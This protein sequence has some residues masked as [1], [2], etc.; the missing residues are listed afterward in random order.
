MG[1]ILKRSVFPICCLILF[2]SPL[3]AEIVLDGSTGSLGQIEAPDGNYDIRM[4]YGHQAG[5]NLF[6]SFS[7]FNIGTGETAAF[8]VSS[9]I[10][11]IISRVT[12]GSESFIDGTIRSLI[13]DTADISAANLYLLNP[14]GILFGPNAALDMGGSFH[15]STADYLRMGESERFYSTVQEN[16]ILSSAPPWAFGFLTDPAPIRFEG[17]GEVGEDMVSGLTVA[18]LQNISVI[19]GDISLTGTF[20]TDG[21]AEKPLGNLSAPGGSLNLVSAASPGEV[22]LSGKGPDTSSVSSLGNI[23]LSDHSLIKATGTGSGNIF[24]RA[25]QFVMENNSVLEMDT[26]GDDPGGISDI[27]AETVTIRSSD[28]F[29]DA[30][31]TGSGGDISIS[32]IGGNS[33]ESVMISEGS[34]V[35]ANAAN[36]AAHAGDAGNVNIHT[37]N[38]TLSGSSISSSTDGGGSSGNIHLQAEQSLIITDQSEVFAS[39]GS[40]TASGDSGAISIE[41]PK[42]LL[43]NGS[44]ISIDT[45]EGDGGRLRLGGAGESAAESVTV[46]GSQIFAGTIGS[47]NAGDV[48]IHADHIRFDNKGIIGSQTMGSGRGGDI[49]IEVGSSFTLTEGAYISSESLSTENGGEAGHISLWSGDSL[50]LRD[51]RISTG[52]LNAGGGKISL[53]AANMIYCID[54]SVATSVAKGA[55][56]AGDISIAPRYE[57]MQFAILNRSEVLANAYEGK[58]GNIRIETDQFISSGTSRVD[59]S[60]KLGIDGTVNIVSPETDVSQGLVTLPATLMD[61][62]RWALTPCFRRSGSDVSSFVIHG[63]DGIPD[64]PDDWQT[65]FPC[66]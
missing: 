17:M 65:G 26:K 35:F 21:T 9:A 46:S 1:K 34:R 44:K 54:S 6:H 7:R 59:A 53:E 2:F 18:P 15:V 24:I 14:S 19:G 51:S 49:R 38:L 50:F 57:Q 11:N 31:G 61:A 41:S 10:R 25:G 40:H 36:T 64:A 33:A 16:E 3:H 28:I 30:T 52:A 63:Q 23:T 42:T 47:G 56:D 48:L 32:G 37:K 5:E 13:S 20:R 66:F 29:S 55:D 22:M 12:G 43:S 8:G 45:N 58:G 27:Q 4:N 39:S 60:S 62:A